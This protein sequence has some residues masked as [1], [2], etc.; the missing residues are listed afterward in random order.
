MSDQTF[1][2]DALWLSA[3][4]FV[5]VFLMGDPR[6]FHYLLGL[7]PFAPLQGDGGIRIA[8]IQ[9]DDGHAPGGTHFVRFASSDRPDEP[10]GCFDVLAARWR[11]AGGIQLIGAMDVARGRFEPDE[12]ADF[13]NGK[14]ASAY[15]ASQD[16]LDRRLATLRHHP[17]PD[18]RYRV[19]EF[20][21]RDDTLA[22]HGFQADSGEQ[23]W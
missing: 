4:F 1:L 11:H 5:C 16:D 15:V 23:T 3:T 6:P 8:G 17:D 9:E 12:F 14:L 7:I 21:C 18:S 19:H 20:F 2:F 22:A 13:L 10:R